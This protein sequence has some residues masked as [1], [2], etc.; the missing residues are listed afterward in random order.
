MFFDQQEKANSLLKREISEP[1]YRALWIN[2]RRSISPKVEGWCRTED[3]D[4]LL[5]VLG[6]KKI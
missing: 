3:G 5:T 1:L 4:K 2:S 6:R